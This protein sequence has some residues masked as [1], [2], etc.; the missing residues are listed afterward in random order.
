[1]GN[2]LISSSDVIGDI[3]QA[4]T[5][6]LYIDSQLNPQASELPILSIW[7]IFGNF[8]RDPQV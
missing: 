5:L 2:Y 6:S 3:E 4:E 1:M 8:L 7:E